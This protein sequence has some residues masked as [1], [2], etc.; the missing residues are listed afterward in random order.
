VLASGFAAWTLYVWA[1]RIRNAVADDALSGADRAVTVAMSLGFVAAALVVGVLVVRSW[2]RHGR[3]DG[4]VQ[5]AMAVTL[6]LTVLVW[7]IRVPMI[8]TDSGRGIP[9]KVVHAMLAVISVGLGWGAR[10]AAAADSVPP[11]ALQPE[12]AASRSG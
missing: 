11:S 10:R 7:A 3:L 5:A 12:R 6:A 8:L 4:S 9:F 2:R 1:T